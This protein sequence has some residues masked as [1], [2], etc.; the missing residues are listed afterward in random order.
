M[1]NKVGSAEF[2]LLNDTLAKP[3]SGMASVRFVNVSPDVSPVDLVE[4]NGPVVVANKAYKGYS[5]FLTV[6]GNASYTFNV[7]K[8]GTSTILATLSNVKLNA[9]YVYT[10]WL[11]GLETPLNNS[12]ILTL[13][14][15]TNAYFN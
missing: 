10:I 6:P 1:A 5:S 14:L 15:I 2:V 3:A 9:N 12:E 4:L 13:G 7:V 8:T 11:Y